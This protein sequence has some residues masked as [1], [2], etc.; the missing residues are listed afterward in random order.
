MAGQEDKER[1]LTYTAKEATKCP[2]C[3]T[4]FRREEL[5]SGRVN[6]GEL[7]DDLRRT[8]IPMQAFGE[9]F[10]LAFDISV[11]PACW[12]AAYKPDF[13]SIP[14]KYA[15]VLKEEAQ[16]RLDSTQRIFGSVDF[17]ASRGLVE[18][19]A[20]YLLAMLSYERLGK[21]YCPTFKQG[22]SSLRAAWLCESLEQ[23]QPGENYG[24][25]AKVFYGKARL[26]YRLAVELDQKGREA[27]GAAKW[28]GPDTDKSYG[29]E[30]VLYLSAALELKYGQREDEAKRAL[31]LDASKR[32]IAKMFGLG[33]RSKAKPGPLVDKV[34][35]LYDALKAE[36]HQ[37]DDEDDD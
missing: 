2:V 31:A 32:T 9:V 15:A 27:L 13:P 16:K 10:P 19:A 7:T 17:S 28:H 23:K 4:D 26:L 25:A 12:F 35:D 22:L 5:F 24:Y 29:Y 11:C 30:G 20:S 34:R 8:W 36:L 21:E 3:G 6:A 18:G 37:D 14:A 33:K 1:K